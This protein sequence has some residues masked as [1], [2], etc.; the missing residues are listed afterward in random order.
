[1]NKLTNRTARALGAGL[2]ALAA[3]AALVAPVVPAAAAQSTKME[4]AVKALRAISTMRA[5]FT[6]TDRSGQQVRG[7]MALKRPGKIR[8]EYQKD[9]PVLIVS[10]GSRLTMLD[11]EVNQKQVWPIKNSPLGALLQP[12]GDISKYGTLMPTNHPGVTSVRIRDPKHPEYGTMTM[13][14]ERKASAPGGMQLA[15]WVSVDS[16]NKMTRIDLTNQR[17][18][19]DIGNGTFMFKDVRARTKR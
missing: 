15:G 18:G 10:D 14:F 19:M 3:P 16:Q 5:S 11:Y 6:Q 9:V 12:D 8:F 7:T 13:I 1:M 4:E 2:L 17:Y